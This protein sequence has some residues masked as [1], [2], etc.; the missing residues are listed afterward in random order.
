[1]ASLKRFFSNKK[2]GVT[3]FILILI[4]LGF[5]IIPSGKGNGINNM[6]LSVISFFQRGVTGITSWVGS[7]I[8]SVAELKEL[9]EKYEQVQEK[10]I[11]YRSIQRRVVE[12][13][14]ENDRL[15]EQLGFREQLDLK[16][17]SAEV[18]AK[19]T[20]NLF[21]SFTINKGSSSGVKNDQPVIAFMNGYR[22]LV[23]KIEEVS[24]NTALVM[25][26]FSAE[27]YS[28]AMLQDSRYQGLVN[29]TGYKDDILL[30]QYVKKQAQ[31]EI[32]YGDIVVTSGMDSIYPENI[33]IG[34]VKAIEVK[35]YKSSL[36]IELEPFTDFARLEYV[37]VVTG[38]KSG[39]K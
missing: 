12:L 28:A 27:F 38:K 3:F 34:R 35:D 5:I 10:L 14:S 33:Y 24:A 16:T 8:N 37:F 22:S 23:G 20:Q 4:S 7:T 17:T 2:T 32:H 25:P 11:Q 19:D 30:M 36:D 18:I 21:Q 31:N 13:E 6:G 1:M 39:E 26:I 15:R 29:G 9:Q